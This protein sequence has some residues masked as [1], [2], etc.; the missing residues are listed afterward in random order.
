MFSCYYY[1]KSTAV[2]HDGGILSAYLLSRT[3]FNKS[4]FIEIA[5]TPQP[6]FFSFELNRT[7]VV[8][9]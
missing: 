5:K 2:S 6:P 7:A 8:A 3:K 4:P 1:F 9:A